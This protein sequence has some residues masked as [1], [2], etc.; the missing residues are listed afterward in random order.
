MTS[1]SAIPMTPQNLVLTVSGYD[2]M[3]NWD[4]VTLDTSQNPINISY[5]EVYVSDQPYFECNIDNLLCTT[6]TPGLFLEGAAEFADRLFF[7]I[8]AV[9]GAITKKNKELPQ[10][11]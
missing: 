1:S 5:Y 3:L 10:K 11:K 4:E 8:K 7:K 6:E 9:S 2:I